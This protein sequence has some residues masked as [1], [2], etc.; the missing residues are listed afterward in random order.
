MQVELSTVVSAFSG[1]CV[2]VIGGYVA[3]LRFALETKEKDFER[4]LSEAKK[5]AEDAEV[6]ASRIRILMTEMQGELA[7]TKQAAEHTRQTILDMKDSHA[8]DQEMIQ[9]G[10]RDLTNELRVM[11]AGPGRYG[12][13]QALPA[14]STTP[15][16]RPDKRR[17]P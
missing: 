15:P 13:T 6:E 12:S 17:E 3:V 11:R 2:F 10:F 9:R 5:I 7:L 16:P 14:A 4:R 8:R 1:I